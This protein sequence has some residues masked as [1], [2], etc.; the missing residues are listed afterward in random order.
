MPEPVVGRSSF[1][2]YAYGEELVAP[3][4]VQATTEWTP[5]EMSMIWEEGQVPLGDLPVL[6]LPNVVVVAGAGIVHEV[7]EAPTAIMSGLPASAYGGV[8][9]SEFGLGQLVLD[10]PEAK[11]PFPVEVCDGEVRVGARGL[12]PVAQA[13]VGLIPEL[14]AEALVQFG[15][16]KTSEVRLDR[17]QDRIHVRMEQHRQE[18]IDVGSLRAGHVVEVLVD[19]EGE[20]VQVPTKSLKDSWVN[21]RKGIGI[22]LWQD[23]VVLDT[24]ILAGFLSDV[25]PLPVDEMRTS[26]AGGV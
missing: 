20:P 15:G 8:A 2:L 5:V 17:A 11:L 24:P 4:L 9:G 7:R 12:S 16:G 25:R 3:E 26:L 22:S 21:R 1:V 18:Q 6:E 14:E 23:C 10:Q 13:P 19:A